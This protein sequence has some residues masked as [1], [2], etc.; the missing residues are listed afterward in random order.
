MFLRV[1][2][3]VTLGV[4]L[5][6]PP[7]T[8]F[9]QVLDAG[10]EA[11]RRQ[12]ER[13]ALERRRE[14]RASD[15]FLPRERVPLGPE[16]LP[17]ERPCFAIREIALHGAEPFAWMQPLAKAYRDQCIGRQG[18]NLIV[19]RLTGELLE[20]GYITTR[21]TIPEQDLADGTLDLIVVPGVVREI[22][23]AE[24][25]T[26][27]NWQT[28]FPTRPG[29]VLDL[30]A[31][32]Q[33]VEQMKR[34]PSQDVE[35]ELVPGARPGESDVVITR[36]Q[37]RRLRGALSVDDSG[38]DATGRYIGS[39]TIALD[40]PLGLNDL[41]YISASGA[42]DRESGRRGNEGLSGF[43]SVPW[44]WWTFSAFA[45]DFRF[46]QT[47]QGVAQEFVS[48]GETRSIDVRASRMVHRTGR[49][50]TAILLRT[51]VR[52][53]ES[54]IDDV[55]ILNQNRRL[56]AA[57]IGVNHRQFVERAILDATIAFRAGVP[58]FSAEAPLD[59]SNSE[60]PTSRYR[61]WTVD[62]LASAPL[63]IGALAPRYSAQFRAQLTTDALFPLDYFSIG[64]RFTVRGFDGERTLA[65]DR[66]WL[67]RNELALPLPVA[68]H[69]AFIGIDTGAVGGAATRFL[70][71]K[72]L[73]GAVIGLRGG[74][75]G[76]LYEFFAGWAL[77]KPEGFRTGNPALG[78]Q[79]L[80]Q[81]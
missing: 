13:E 73:T 26:P 64:N 68:Q 70:P 21:V 48:S 25:S 7:A 35:I 27:G 61:L 79:L 43:Y 30:R 20:R 22:R 75:K 38:V 46:R 14:E 71:G 44:G 10:A 55:E 29:D 16:A 11:F 60:V 80:Y 31:L 19:R 69:E 36:R 32:E 76:L 41:A 53:A 24:R 47:I 67:L 8:G 28:A 40:G 17:E 57:E 45:S 56:T 58:W 6:I 49:S 54:F 3:L 12:E 63:Q 72:N 50:K 74:W 2:W 65:A 66:G 77:S 37:D 9:T 33:G 78:F 81:I 1:V 5:A 62:A 42:L 34:L 39:A 52:R 51:N 4:L 18:I 15:A 59:A 23:F